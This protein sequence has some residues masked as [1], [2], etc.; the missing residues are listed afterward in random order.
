PTGWHGPDC[1]M[2]CPAGTWGLNCNRSCDC[3]HGAS[4][5]PQSGTCSCPR[6]WQGPR[7]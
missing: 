1:S 4:C 3:A 5:D 6:G 7:C 2:P